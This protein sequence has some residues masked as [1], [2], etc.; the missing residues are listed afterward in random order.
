MG[1]GLGSGVWGVVSRLRGRRWGTSEWC[2]VRQCTRPHGHTPKNR[3]WEQRASAAG[4]SAQR[5][6]DRAISGS[7]LCNRGSSQ[8]L[9]GCL[10][11][12]QIRAGTPRGMGSHLEITD[13]RPGDGCPKPFATE[14]EPGG[15][16]HS[17]YTQACMCTHM[18]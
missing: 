18:R 6:T 4:T 5:P 8:P 10:V 2:H 7:G 13:Y 16:F 17:L 1:L 14:G 3:Q 9:P 15:G 12:L 11:H